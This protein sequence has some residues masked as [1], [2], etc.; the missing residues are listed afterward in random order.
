LH[1]AVIAALGVCDAFIVRGHMAPRRAAVV[2]AIQSE[3]ADKID[4]L[5]VGADRDRDGDA[6]GETWEPASEDLVPGETAVRRFVETRARAG[7]AKDGPLARPWRSVAQG[8]SGQHHGAGSS[9]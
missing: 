1:A 2:G 9:R 3:I 4:A 8:R 6:T 7:R 5:R